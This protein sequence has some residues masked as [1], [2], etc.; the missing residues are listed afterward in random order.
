MYPSPTGPRIPH[1]HPPSCHHP[2][3]RQNPVDLTTIQERLQSRAYYKTLDIFAADVIR[4]LSNAK[5][6]AGVGGYRWRRWP[7]AQVQ[8]RPRPRPARTHQPPRRVRPPAAPGP[9]SSPPPHRSFTMR[10][11]RC[12]TRL[13][14]GWPR[15][16]SSGWKLASSGWSPADGAGSAAP[17]RPLLADRV[18]RTPHRL[19]FLDLCNGACLP[20]AHR[21]PRDAAHQ[22]DPAGAAA[23]HPARR[24]RRARCMPVGKAGRRRAAPAISLGATLPCL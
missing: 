18:S 20:P 8:A 6:R 1:R 3:L 12:F 10:Q 21:Q 17:A 14:C 23:P 7:D 16:S 22:G 2:G 9:P 11:T 19:A 5:A 13:R 15:S 4:M 24:H